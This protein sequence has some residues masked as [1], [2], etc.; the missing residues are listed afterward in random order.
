MRAQNYLIAVVAT[1]LFS[2]MT[3]V[4]TSAETISPTNAP[5]AQTAADRELRSRISAEILRG[6]CAK[7]K[8]LAIEASD[9]DLAEQVL[10][11]C[12]PK[13]EGQ[14]ISPSH[15]VNPEKD[16]AA[17][18]ALFQE[19]KYAEAYELYQ[20]LYA[21]GNAE[22]A[23]QIGIMMQTGLGVPVNKT[24][25]I[26]YFKFAAD[27]GLI[28][29]FYN[30][31]YVNY[32]GI[33]TGKD[34]KKAFENFQQA[35][36]R[37]HA[38]SQNYLG[39]MY[40][41]GFGVGKNNELALE[42]YK[43]AA[44]N[45]SSFAQQNISALIAIGAASPSDLTIPVSGNYN[46]EWRRKPTPEQVAGF[47]PKNAALQK[48][49]ARVVV[50]CDITVSGETEN[51]TVISESPGGYG[52]SDAA[53]KLVRIAEFTPRI[54]DGKPVKSG[55]NI[56]LIFDLPDSMFEKMIKSLSASK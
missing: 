32:A 23:N 10:R 12:V 28:N 19:K 34:Y 8:S 55:V 6:D 44:K 54:V 31:G 33:G 9:F 21:M 45:G 16:I 47:Y 24:K 27:R 2:F 50:H 46:P 42:W 38:E 49:K 51:C 56:P 7:A 18:N 5:S 43:R 48:V 22:A 4:G 25:A 26:P 40:A 17:A 14:N 37:E 35:A 39:L 13:S 20:T 3:C 1:A 36:E 53:L 11:L 52:F 41:N 30:L 15:A 29:G